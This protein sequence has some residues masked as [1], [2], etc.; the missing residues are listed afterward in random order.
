MPAVDFAAKPENKNSTKAEGYV[1][2]NS[3]SYHWKSHWLGYRWKYVFV[4]ALHIT[5]KWHI[6]EGQCAHFLKQEGVH[7]ALHLQFD[8]SNNIRFQMLSQKNLPKTNNYTD[9]C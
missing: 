3:L 6:D 5:C 2:S 7:P 8:L 9:S 1:A 4:N